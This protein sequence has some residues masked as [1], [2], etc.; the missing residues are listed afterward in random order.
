[1]LFRSF[2]A[3]ICGA[4]PKGQ[5]WS[6]VEEWRVRRGV[7]A[8][9]FE[10]AVRVATVRTGGGASP[11]AQAGGLVVSAA[12]TVWLPGV[13]AK[14]VFDYICDGDRRGEWDTFSNHAPVQL[15]DYVAAV[16]FPHYSVSVLHPKVIKLHPSFRRFFYHH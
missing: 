11:G 3:T 5:P 4:S 14:H 1:M 2:C 10:V 6:S 8:D 7:G 9:S 16:Q 12:T 13:P 15:E